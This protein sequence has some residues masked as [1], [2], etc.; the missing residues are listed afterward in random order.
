MLALDGIVEIGEDDARP[1][2]EAAP[3]RFIDGESDGI[4]RRNRARAIDTRE[5]E[6]ESQFVRR[7]IRKGKRWDDGCEGCDYSRPSDRSP[8]AYDRA[9]RCRCA[10]KSKTPAATEALSEP[11]VPNIG[12]RTR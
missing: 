5:R 7:R 2:V 9:K 8:R 6:V 1:T 12:M 4:A 3:V 10:S 11:T